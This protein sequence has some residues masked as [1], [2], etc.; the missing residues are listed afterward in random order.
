V[1]AARAG[2]SASLGTPAASK[3]CN[4]AAFPIP[5]TRLAAN[6]PDRRRRH[7][8]ADRLECRRHHR[9]VL[10]QDVNFDGKTAGSLLAGVD[11]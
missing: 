5:A 9:G 8:V 2:R 10:A 7:P 11:D 3:F 1:R 4:G 6:G